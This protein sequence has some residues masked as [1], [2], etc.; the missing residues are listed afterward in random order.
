VSDRFAL[1]AVICPSPRS[2]PEDLQLTLDA[3]TP[4]CGAVVF[5][6]G[7]GCEIYGVMVKLPAVVSRTLEWRLDDEVR[8]GALRAAAIGEY[9]LVIDPGETLENGE[10]L[11]TWCETR[12]RAASGASELESGAGNGLWVETRL[13]DG[14]AR[15]ERRVVRLDARPRY[16]GAAAARLL[17]PGE[18]PVARTAR[19]VAK[20]HGFRL[21]YRVSPPV[22]PLEALLGARD[23]LVDELSER[24][25][26]PRP[27]LSPHTLLRLGLV[28]AWLGL[29][30]AARSTLERRLRDPSRDEE[31]F[32][33]LMLAG[34][35]FENED[36]GRSAG[37]YNAAHL[38][39]SDRAEP[40][41]GMAQIDRDGRMHEA[42]IMNAKRGLAQPLPDIDSALGEEASKVREDLAR[43]LASSAYSLGK[44]DLV[45]TGY[46]LVLSEARARGA[47]EWQL[48]LDE[49]ALAEAWGHLGRARAD[50]EK[51]L[52]LPLA[53][54]EPPSGEETKR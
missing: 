27:M 41:L 2:T 47:S 42:A 31:D 36:P 20:E 37:L 54:T 24:D 8:N 43:V 6:L 34:F 14:S 32:Y 26:A 12:A 48:K 10:E 11:K 21:T 52:A 9:A 40:F 46:K 17:V 13:P 1:V 45:V 23:A 5:G 3:I 30:D 18:L 16:E 19:V 25:M 29:Y 35:L 4:W 15:L 44:W 33:A 51:Q 7:D 28:E 50:A 49:S 39:F 53:D 38:H 22:L